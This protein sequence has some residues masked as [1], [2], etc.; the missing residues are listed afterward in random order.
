MP[1]LRTP[2]GAL[3]STLPRFAIVGRCGWP[4]RTAGLGS[5]LSWERGKKQ[6]QTSF[7]I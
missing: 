5:R 6:Y 3:D 2:S 1:M 7:A 4:R